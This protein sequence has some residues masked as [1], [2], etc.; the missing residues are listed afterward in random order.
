M[1]PIIILGKGPSALHLPK[2]EKYDVAAVAALLT[3]NL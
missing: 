3:C 2:S 1:K